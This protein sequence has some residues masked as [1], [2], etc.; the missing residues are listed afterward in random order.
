M[1]LR[2]ALDLC[3]RT[4]MSASFPHATIRHSIPYLYVQA[5]WPQYVVSTAIFQ[6]EKWEMYVRKDILFE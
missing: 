2:N 4:V 1:S 5:L 6:H 3:T